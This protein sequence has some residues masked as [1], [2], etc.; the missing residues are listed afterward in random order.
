MI[1]MYEE[2]WFLIG[3]KGVFI[4]VKKKQKKME[5]KNKLKAYLSFVI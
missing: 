5:K 4:V 3:G 1:E 2:G